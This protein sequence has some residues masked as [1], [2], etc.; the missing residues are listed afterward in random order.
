MR[1]PLRLRITLAFAVG[2][3]AVLAFLGAFLYLRLG[4]ELRGSIDAGLRS[5]A[6]VIEAGAGRGSFADEPGALLAADEAFAQLLDA[7]GAIR[8]SSSA[9]G[10]APLVPPS[11]LPASGPAFTDLQ[12]PGIEGPSRILVTPVGADHG[13]YVVVGATLSDRAEAL[14]GLLVLLALG[15]PGALLL[16]SAAGW[17]LAGAAL[18]PVERMREEAASISASEPARRLAVPPADDEL[19]RLATTLNAMLD[20]LQDSLAGERRFVD[21]ASHELRTPLAI[22]K[23][24]LDLALSH[25]RSRQQLQ[26]ALGRAS[27]ETDRLAALAEDLLVLARAEGDRLPVTR[28]E[29]LLSLL[30]ETTIAGRRRRSRDARVTVETSASEELVLIDPVRVRQALENLLDNALRY[31]PADSRVRIVAVCEDELVRITVEDSGPGFA[32]SVLDRA[33]EPFTRTRHAEDG[34]GLGLA[35][36]G[37]VAASH[38]GTA[39]AQN[40]PGGG[41]RVTILLRT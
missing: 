33:F 8:E 2:M 40:L 39:T 9:V 12:V 14:H 11:L 23:G 19:R 35:I 34:A 38:G 5:R 6:Q 16:T 13:L 26:T 37:A 29:V 24:E 7:S 1:L 31:S 20:R 32:P 36:V 28:E 10:G 4:A 21:D 41:A 3:A 17:M 22:L 27:A 25:E 30:V 15:G 18:R